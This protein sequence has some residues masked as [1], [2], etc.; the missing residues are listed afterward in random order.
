MFKV[1]Y[2]WVSARCSHCKVFGHGFTSC[3]SNPTG[4]NTLEKN[5]GGTEYYVNNEDDH[6]DPGQNPLQLVLSQGSNAS[7]G[8]FIFGGRMDV[9]SL[10]VDERV[11]D[12]AQSQGV[13]S[14]KELTS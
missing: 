12:S 10:A 5:N 8:G 4:T 11:E 3:G 7:T 14:G 9:N 13:Q 6:E 1:E 2:E